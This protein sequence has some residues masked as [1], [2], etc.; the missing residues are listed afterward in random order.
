MGSAPEAA[1]RSWKPARESGAAL[2]NVIVSNRKPPCG[3]EPGYGAIGGAPR[4]AC[5][6][7]AVTHS[8]SRARARPSWLSAP[9]PPPPAVC[10]LR[11][12]GKGT[13][14][15]VHGRTR[16][17][18]AAAAS[19]APSLRE[20]GGESRSILLRRSVSALCSCCHPSAPSAKRSAAA[21]AAGGSGGDSSNSSVVGSFA[22]EVVSAC[23][24]REAMRSASSTTT[25][26][27][28]LARASLPKRF[29][30]APT[31]GTGSATPE[32]STSTTSSES[33]PSVSCRRLESWDSSS[34][35]S[36]WQTQP[37]LSS[38]TCRAAS[39][40]TSSDASTL[41]A[42][43]SLTK[44]LT[45]RF[46]RLRRMWLRSVVL[47]APSKPLSTTT[48]IGRRRMPRSSIRSSW[49]AKRAIRSHVSHVRSDMRDKKRAEFLFTLK[50]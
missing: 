35:A 7:S 1:I 23:G 47:P 27:S 43:T 6:F 40:R 22:E 49:W 14:A 18:G 9:P 39:R 31:T 44:A 29:E 32:V 21:A 33:A 15:C 28:S 37:L 13:A 36:P 42:A 30:I 25:T 50:C 41:S 10:T 38:T 17:H 11:I 20:R 4:E 16:A 46:C 24:S 8:P 19:A 2:S 12:D 45:R 3:C 48:G 5:A 26:E 34:P